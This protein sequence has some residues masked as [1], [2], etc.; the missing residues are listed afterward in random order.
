MFTS[1]EEN[2]EI[3][4][5]EEEEEDQDKDED[6]LEGEEDIDDNR[7]TDYVGARPRRMSDLNIPTKI[8]PIPKYSSFFIFSHTN[9]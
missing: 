4:E 8:T 3:D 9:R 2:V 5:E 7:I 1:D 6:A